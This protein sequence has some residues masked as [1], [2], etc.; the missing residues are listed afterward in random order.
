MGNSNG[1]NSDCSKSF[2]HSAVGDLKY[3]RTWLAA[4]W[5]PRFAA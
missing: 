1:K 5:L 2:A 3:I 4:C